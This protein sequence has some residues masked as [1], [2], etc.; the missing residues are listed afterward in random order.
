M[1]SEA[2]AVQLVCRRS[3][4]KWTDLRQC[5]RLVDSLAGSLRI[6]P[7]QRRPAHFCE[8]NDRQ[9]VSKEWELL[10][11]SYHILS[12]T[13]QSSIGKPQNQTNRQFFFGK[14][15]NSSRAQVKFSESAHSSR[16]RWWWLAMHEAHCLH[17]SNTA[18][19][20]GKP[21]KTNQDK[22]QNRKMLRKNA[23][24]AK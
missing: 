7:N 9:S 20:K 18:K 14:M 4:W 16:S 8:R 24:A 1:E 2:A 10:L 13:M 3:A 21:R 23:S 5:E 17:N 22:N 12:R 15:E 11:I 6:N 19:L